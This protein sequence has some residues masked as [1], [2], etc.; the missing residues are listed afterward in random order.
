MDDFLLR[1]LAA[2]IGIAAVCGMLGVFVVWRRLAYFGDTIAHSALLGVALGA[3]F[4]LAP[5]LPVMAVAAAVALALRGLARRRAWPSDTVLGILSHSALALGLVVLALLGEPRVDLMAM[6]FGDILAVSAGDLYTVLVLGALAGASL[7]ATW[8]T[9]VSATVHAELAQVEGAPVAWVE[10]LL[11]LLVATVV[12]MAMKI[13]GVLLITALLIVPAAAARRLSRGP[14][15]MAVTASVLGILSVIAG[16]A[17]SWRWDT[18]AGP[19]IVV[20]ALLVFIL[21]TGLVPLRGR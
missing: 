16:L 2:G 4:G 7:A 20:A 14:L 18:P 12:A 8:R 11:M 13:V 6:L 17:G 15:Q 21:T 19:S 9:L 10:S 3:A 1:A 5:E